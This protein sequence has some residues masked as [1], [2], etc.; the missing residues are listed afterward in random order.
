MNERKLANGDVATGSDE[1]NDQEL[2]E[3]LSALEACKARISIISSAVGIALL[4]VFGFG[5]VEIP[6][7]A[8]EAAKSAAEVAAKK[9]VEKQIGPDVQKALAEYSQRAKSAAEAAE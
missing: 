5:A 3:R 2:K 7:R 6:N 4:I 8:M 9:E 1:G